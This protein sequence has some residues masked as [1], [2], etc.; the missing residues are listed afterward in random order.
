MGGDHV[1]VYVDAALKNNACKYGLVV[2]DGN[3]Q[4]MEAQAGSM[5]PGSPLDAE[6]FAIWKALQ[7]L[8]SRAFYL[9]GDIL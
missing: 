5:S 2:L 4:F 6:C 3:H 9:C 7:Y 1:R 8:S